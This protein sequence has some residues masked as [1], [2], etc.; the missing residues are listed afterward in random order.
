MDPDIDFGAVFNE[1]D[2][3]LLGRRPMTRSENELRDRFYS[4]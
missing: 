4:I 2:T 3:I 1:F